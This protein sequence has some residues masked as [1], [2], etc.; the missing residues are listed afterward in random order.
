MPDRDSRHLAITPARLVALA[1]AVWLGAQRRDS[2]HPAFCGWFDWHSAVHGTLALLLL[3]RA[4]AGDSPLA[5]GLVGGLVGGTAP[6]PLSLFRARAEDILRTD[7]IDAEYRDVL[8][9][10]LAHELPY[11]FAWFLRLAQEH[12]AQTGSLHLSDLANHLVGEIWRHVAEAPPDMLRRGLASQEYK[13]LS[14]A[15]IN[16]LE[17]SRYTENQELEARLGDL[18]A[19]AV[20]PHYDAAV[21]G[22]S[23]EIRGFFDPANLLAMLIATA[24][25]GK[26]PAASDLLLRL[27][28]IDR[29]PRPLT[30]FPT[31]H[32]A[33]LNFSRCWGYRRL[34]EAT[35]EAAYLESFHETF[36]THLAILREQCADYRKYGHWVGQFGV[37]ALTSP[38]GRGFRTAPVG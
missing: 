23:G 9:G 32:S 11:G 34:Y 13:N 20:A 7:L 2:E 4:A 6:A 25:G 16:A 33:G 31:V 30:E 27:V 5:G 26:D 28:P 35:G 17:W 38:P 21:E 14:W 37:Y 36:E 15:L 19:G 24:Q 18:V 12:H 3:H 1:D 10:K 29:P 8:A 22:A